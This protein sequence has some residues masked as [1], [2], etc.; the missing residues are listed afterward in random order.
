MIE[1][2]EG[3]YTWNYRA[4]GPYGAF[5][6][7]DLYSII[8]SL[9]G[10]CV[11]SRRQHWRLKLLREQLHSRGTV[12]LCTASDKLELEVSDTNKALEIRM[13]DISVGRLLQDV[14]LKGN[15]EVELVVGVGDLG[16]LPSEVQLL[17]SLNNFPVFLITLT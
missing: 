10:T 17:L 8:N 16:I 7:K 4:A 3:S 12:P 15:S 11:W 13:N 5:Q 1:E 6:A 2:T 14:I 9:I